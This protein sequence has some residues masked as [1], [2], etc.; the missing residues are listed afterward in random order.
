MRTVA[1]WRKIVFVNGTGWLSFLAALSWILGK[2]LGV[3]SAAAGIV[4]MFAF[5]FTRPEV[6][7]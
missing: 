4:A 3:V 7:R 2:P 6:P 1:F 5:L